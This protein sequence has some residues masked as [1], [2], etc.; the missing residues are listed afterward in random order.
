MREKRMMASSGVILT[1]QELEKYLE[2]IGTTHD[3]TAKTSKQTYPIPRL[4]E[5]YS[6]IK[7]VYE[8]LNE[9]VKLKI[10]IHPAGEWIL[11]NFYIIEETVK[12]IRKELT[13]K[14]YTNFVGLKNG[15][16]AGFARVFVLASEIVNC[17]DNKIRTENLEKYLTAYQTK[18][19]LNMDEIWN[20]GI[21]LQL[22][23]IENIRQICER[24]YISQIEKLKVELIVESLIEKKSI[25]KFKTFKLNRNL[26]KFSDEKYPFIEYMSYKLKRYGKK[27]EKYLQVLEEIVEKTGNTVGE[28]IKKEHF[29]IANRRVSI[30]NCITSI[31]KIQRINFLEIFEKINGVEEILKLDPAGVYDKMD[32]KTKDSYRQAIKEISKKSKISEIYIARKMLELAKKGHGK[33]QHIGYYLFDKNKNILYQ[34]IGCKTRKTLNRNQKVEYYI[35]T[36]IIFTVILAL[37]MVLKLI[38]KVPIFLTI[39]GFL[40]LLIPISEFVIQIIQYFL[41]K[42]VKPKLIPKMDFYNGIDKKN[43]TMVIIPTVLKSRKKVEELM[44]KLE[45][46]YLANKSDNLYFCLLGD[47][48]ES[49]KKVE[50]FDQDIIDEGTLQVKKLNE[51]YGEIFGFVYRKRKWNEKQSSYLGWERKRGAITE[52]VEFLLG[53]MKKEELENS[54][55]INTLSENSIIPQITYIITLDSDTDLVLNSAFELVGAMAH[56][57]NKPEFKDGRVVNGYGLIQPRVGVNIDVSYKNM[58]TKIFAGSRWYRFI[59]KCYF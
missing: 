55:Y 30:G 49:N 9:H 40:L 5:N 6:V 41:S 34:K 36:I 3:L 18:K 44:K 12:T 42:I 10:S 17:T 59:Y 39:I 11:D 29:E 47:C 38:N 24:I 53:N 52:F 28:I 15:Q 16:F 32:Y 7:N 8:I 57:L 54:Y 45:V 2:K 58:F 48:S 33:R 13:L 23:I 4:L 27:T 19:T 35:S 25:S 1:T 20:I 37:I 50:D 31:K 21:F 14:K 46:F 51:K 43:A 26:R 22:A 56:I